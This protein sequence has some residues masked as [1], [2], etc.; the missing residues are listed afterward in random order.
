[1]A[2]SEK[3]KGVVKLSQE[4]FET[5][6][7]SGSLIVDGKTYT[8]S[9]KDTMYV[10]PQKPI[11]TEIFAK[12]GEENI[13]TAKNTFTEE[14]LFE[15]ITEFDSDVKINNG[16]LKILDNTINS[17]KT[18]R[19][20]VTQYSADNIVKETNGNTYTYTFQDKSGLFAFITDTI[21]SIL[22]KS[23]F[24]AE[25][26]DDV[27]V[28][29]EIDSSVYMKHENGTSSAGT[30]ASKNYAELFAIDTAEEKT[31]Q[32]SVTT[33]GDSVLI[34]AKDS[35]GTEQNLSIRS[36]GITF[37][38]KP[39]VK[40]SE[41]DTSDVVIESDLTNYVQTQSETADGY[42]AQ[43]SNE[44]GIVQITISQN[45]QAPIH[46]LTISK[47]SILVDGKTI[48]ADVQTDGATITKNSDD[49]LQAVSL[50]D[51]TDSK[52][53]TAQKLRKACTIKRYVYDN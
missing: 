25:N 43:I 40:T 31:N 7:D 14:I 28:T 47:D 44:N 10:T 36:D 30:R 3:Y 21:N 45:G 23:K 33:S 34:T 46:S 8:Y 53:M 27:W 35:L 11:D 16:T 26:G 18:Q 12:V 24:T 1:M 9:P 15:G 4:Q 39:K 20:I 38:D 51:I 6:R 29:S 32:A 2:T 22:Q 17:D 52:L 41:T 50:I 48:G 19:D 13:F 42:Y 49:K 37:S 5:L